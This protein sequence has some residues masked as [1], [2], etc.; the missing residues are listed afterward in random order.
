M[1]DL[2]SVKC[3]FNIFHEGRKYTG[4]HR[5]Y[6]L[7]NARQT[8]NS[9]AIQEKIKL[10]EAT[11]YY[12]HGRRI[13][14][15]RME[16]QEVELVKMP[17]GSSVLI[18]NVPSNTTTSLSVDDQGTVVHTQD[19]LETNTGKIVSNL[20][21]SRIGGFSWACPGNDGADKGVSTL[22]GFAG[23]DYVLN[24][25][26][27]VNRGYVLESVDGLDQTATR[28]MILESIVAAG[29]QDDDNQAEALLQGWMSDAHFMAG[30]MQQ[31]LGNAES[32]LAE[33]GL[34]ETAITN[35]LAGKEKDITDLEGSLQAA[36]LATKTKEARYVQLVNFITESVPF[37]IPEDA[38]SDMMEGDFYKAQQI[39]ES[40]RMVDF[41]MYPIPGNAQDA[42]IKGSNGSSASANN[43]SSDS[44]FGDWDL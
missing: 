9:P 3:S 23:M 39:F 7:E 33:A 42:K 10:R 37:V 38:M 44:N 24:P 16:L 36:L 1:D 25:G 41:G 40:A 30:Q 22:S 17:D 32:L 28:D 29:L 20:N 19:I 6:V 2:E 26:F 21:K 5:K 43:K 14:A 35:K 4:N 12:G 27:A 31:Q 15:G 13:L 8:C 34:F 11:G 18:S